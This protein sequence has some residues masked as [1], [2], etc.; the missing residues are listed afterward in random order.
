MS[1]WR[2]NRT[3]EVDIAIDPRG[4]ETPETVSLLE[5]WGRH[6]FFLICLARTRPCRLRVGSR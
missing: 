4:L 2:D 6:P 3:K 1:R 5:T